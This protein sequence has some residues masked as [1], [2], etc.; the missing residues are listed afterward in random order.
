MARMGKAESKK[1]SQ[2]ETKETK[3]ERLFINDQRDGLRTGHNSLNRNWIFTTKGA[4][5]DNG[6]R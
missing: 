4:K 3:R 1:S 5:G 2:E 6:L